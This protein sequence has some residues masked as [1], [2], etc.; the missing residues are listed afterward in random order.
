MSEYILDTNVLLNNPEFIKD[1]EVILLPI[2]LRE[3][4][5]LEL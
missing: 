4:E 3:L 2:M 1:N 5:N